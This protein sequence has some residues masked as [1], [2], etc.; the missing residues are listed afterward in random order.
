MSNMLNTLSVSLSE[1]TG[2]DEVLCRGVL[3]M[4]I[5]NNVQHLRQMTDPVKSSNETMTYITK[6]TYQDWKAIIE[7]PAL[8]RMLGA[9]GLKETSILKTHLMQ[10]LVEQQSL[11]TMGA[12]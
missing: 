3:R 12:R 4:A 7:G 9:I 6:M 10:T 11:F 8:S 2:E 1:A 5:K